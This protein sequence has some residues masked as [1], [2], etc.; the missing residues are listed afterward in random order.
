M[1]EIFVEQLLV[2]LRDNA[3]STS[4][5]TDLIITHGHID[6]C[7]NMCLFTTANIYM[8]RDLARSHSEYTTFEVNYLCVFQNQLIRLN[9]LVF[10]LEHSDSLGDDLYDRIS[11][12]FR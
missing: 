8:D 10:L 11:L 1:E 12:I 3:L 6:H 4:E 7:G 5:I 9:Y 2:A